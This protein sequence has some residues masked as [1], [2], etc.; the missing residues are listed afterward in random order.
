MFGGI[1][2]K[3]FKKL[4]HVCLSNGKVPEDRRVSS[5]FLFA[6]GKWTKSEDTKVRVIS[7]PLSLSKKLYGRIVSQIVKWC[8][9]GNVEG[10][11]VSFCVWLC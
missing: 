3:W 2:I 8:G 10:V 4:F 7:L 11:L 6:Q 9:S 5:L 1:M